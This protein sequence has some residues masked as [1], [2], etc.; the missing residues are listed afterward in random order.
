MGSLDLTRLRVWVVCGR[1]RRMYLEPGS[2]A[3]HRERQNGIGGSDLSALF[4]VSR[5]ET[6]FGLW[7]L[8]TDRRLCNI[9]GAAARRGTRLEP[10]VCERFERETGVRLSAAPQFVR[11]ARWDEGV[12]LLANPD[13]M[14]ASGRWEGMIYEAKTTTEGSYT[15]RLY[16]EGQLPPQHM[17][18]L[19]HYA[20]SLGA[21]GGIITCLSCPRG[22]I[23]DPELD[24]RAVHLVWKRSDEARAIIEECSAAWWTRYVEADKAPQYAQHAKAGALIEVLGA[25][26]WIDEY[27]RQG[28]VDARP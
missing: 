24:C 15:H 17:F 23:I 12:R 7:E 19:Q 5:F 22:P 16:M 18:Q 21:S 6:P 27:P 3:W 11:H 13:R 9:G 2:T 14:L 4:G 10:Y 20:A 1:G 26:G 28:H 25:E 8:K